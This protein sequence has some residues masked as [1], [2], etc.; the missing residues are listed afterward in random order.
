MAVTELAGNLNSTS[1]ASA[2]TAVGA[3]LAGLDAFETLTIFA[4]LTGATGGTLDV[5]LQMSPDAGT[6]WVDYIHYAQILAAAGAASKLITVTRLTNSGTAPIAVGT[7]TTPALAANTIV[8]G[9]WGDRLRVLYVAGA[10]TTAG[11][12][13]VIQIV[14]ST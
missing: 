6:T 8:G 1:P 13:Q 11:A 3:T 14:G 9:N 4:T 2:T 12:A 7:G 5:Y 10:S